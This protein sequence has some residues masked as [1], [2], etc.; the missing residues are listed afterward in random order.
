MAVF[1]DA[2]SVAPAV[3]RRCGRASM[4]MKEGRGGEEQSRKWAV[5]VVRERGGGG[6]G[7]SGFTVHTYY[8]PRL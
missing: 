3:S 8:N 4:Q 1:V 6:G 2:A 7:N 5:P